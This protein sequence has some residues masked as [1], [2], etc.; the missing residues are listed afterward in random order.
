M[1]FENDNSDF[2]LPDYDP[3]FWLVAS[4]ALLLSVTP[5]LALWKLIDIGLWIIGV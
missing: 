5:V 1:T 3:P 4:L 2:D